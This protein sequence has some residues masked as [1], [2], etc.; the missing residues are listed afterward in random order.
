M[1]VPVRRRHDLA[2]LAANSLFIVESSTRRYRTKSEGRTIRVSSQ[3]APDSDRKIQTEATAVHVYTM[4]EAAAA[5]LIPYLG[6]SSTS[7]ITV[8]MTVPAA[9]YVL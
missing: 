2:G 9:M 4:L 7:R 3:P 8:R 6:I 5:P 1:R